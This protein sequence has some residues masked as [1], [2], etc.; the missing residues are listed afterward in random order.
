MAETG[1][2]VAMVAVTAA[3]MVAETAAET[4]TKWVAVKKAATTIS[5]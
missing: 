2:A 3:A 1:T 4:A 5:R